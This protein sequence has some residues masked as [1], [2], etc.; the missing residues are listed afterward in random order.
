MRQLTQAE[1]ELF[2]AYSSTQDTG[3]DTRAAIVERFGGTDEEAVAVMTEVTAALKA[4]ER[5]DF[6]GGTVYS[7]DSELVSFKDAC[8]DCSER[9]LDELVWNKNDVVMCQ[10]CGCEYVP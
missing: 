8:P 7:R 4:G 1:G 5:V 10:N 9:R 6:P 2:L 3:T